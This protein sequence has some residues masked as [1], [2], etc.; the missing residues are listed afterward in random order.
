MTATKTTS[1]S[2]PT[3]FIKPVPNGTRGAHLLDV[4]NIVSRRTGSANFV[5]VFD[6]GAE[7]VMPGTWNIRVQ[8]FPKGLYSGQKLA[9]YWEMDDEGI[10]RFNLYEVE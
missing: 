10:N 1:A 6:D 5:L 2:A 7:V 4:R 3:Q 8:D 9:A